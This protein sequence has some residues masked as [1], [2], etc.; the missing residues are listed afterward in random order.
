MAKLFVTL[1]RQKQLFNFIF[2]FMRKKFFGLPL[3]C[4][5]LALACHSCKDGAL[6]PVMSDD[7]GNPQRIERPHSSFAMIEEMH[8]RTAR[9]AFESAIRA[10][11]ELYYD[12]YQGFVNEDFGF[13]MEFYTQELLRN[14][15]LDYNVPGNDTLLYLVNFSNNNGFALVDDHLRVL[16]V[17]DNCNFHLS[18][19]N[20]DMSEERFNNNPAKWLIAGLINVSAYC[21]NVY[22]TDPPQFAIYDDYDSIHFNINDY[23]TIGP[24]V[25]ME[26]SQG[27]P[28]NSYCYDQFG[29][30]AYAGC[31][32]I[33]VTGLFSGNVR[34]DFNDGVDGDGYSWLQIIN[35]WYLNHN[36]PIYGLVLNSVSDVLFKRIAKIGEGLQTHYGI[37]SSY[38]F[39][40]NIQ[41]YISQ[42]YDN[43]EFRDSNY[44]LYNYRDYFEN[45]KSLL[46]S[47]V[48][49]IG[50]STGGHAW[51]FDGEATHNYE[52]KAYYHGNS[53]TIAGSDTLMHCRMGW[54]GDVDGYYYFGVFR[55]LPNDIFVDWNELIDPNFPCSSKIQI[56]WYHMP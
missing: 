36:S 29:N 25:K 56:C 27:S 24:F 38:T 14:I 11:K 35:D 39:D 53:T 28:Y 12:K 48:V 43:V 50:N 52:I 21:E 17:N 9:F 13:S 41:D 45:R 42:F 46:A 7:I 1:H 6:S 8:G 20:C 54:G 40:R 5:I 15:S 49:S 16:A 23:D 31:A 32:A 26:L 47:G 18:D 55:H 51:L 10:F 37:F 19:F 30:H 44:P 34:P 3:V 4:L 22:P 33:A 2:H